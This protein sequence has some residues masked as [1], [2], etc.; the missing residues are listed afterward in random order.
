MYWS[1]WNIK[2]LLL[3]ENA[4]WWIH[5]WLLAALTI[6]SLKTIINYYIYNT[7]IHTST[8]IYEII[9]CISSDFYSS[10]RFSILWQILW[11]LHY[12]KFIYTAQ[13]EIRLRYTYYTYICTNRYMHKCIEY[14]YSHSISSSFTNLLIWKFLIAA[15][16]S[17]SF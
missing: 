5:V 12:T 11:W 14:T 10:R 6:I 2:L 13:F 4:R 1:V 16:I 17:L 7:Y 9:C 15:E 8:P 3:I